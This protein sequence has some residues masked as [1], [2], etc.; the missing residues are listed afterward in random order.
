[1]DVFLL[2]GVLLGGF[3]WGRAYESR[4]EGDREEAHVL[5]RAREEMQHRTW[6][7]RS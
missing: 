5:D 3:L 7:P 1:M 6:T 4:T 2:A